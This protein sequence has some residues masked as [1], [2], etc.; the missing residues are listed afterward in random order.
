MMKIKKR[1]QMDSV[2]CN[3]QMHQRAYDLCELCCSL[4]VT[5]ACSAHSTA[6]VS[7]CLLVHCLR[8]TITDMTGR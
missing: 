1:Q 7:S 2:Y 4:L 5:I 8:D 3:Q 6:G